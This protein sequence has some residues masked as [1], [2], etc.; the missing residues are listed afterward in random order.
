MK[1]ERRTMSNPLDPE[2]A[3]RFSE[4]MADPSLSWYEKLYGESE[5][6]VKDRLLHTLHEHGI[7]RIEA[8]YSGGHDEGGIQELS[9]FNRQGNKIEG[10]D[11]W[12]D[13]V[14]QA[15]NDVLSTKFFSWAGEWSAYGTLYVD[16][17]ER[18]AWTEGQMEVMDTDKDPL[19]WKL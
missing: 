8:A 11:N 1:K 18:R 13:P 16:M 12:E 5:Q 14:Y 10:H 7:H 3:A 2:F 19:D 4:R 15:C 17:G 9:A 6:A